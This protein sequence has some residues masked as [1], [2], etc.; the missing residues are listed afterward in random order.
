[1]GEGIRDDGIGLEKAFRLGLGVK[2]WEWVYGWM[3]G[4]GIRAFL[5]CH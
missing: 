4:W 5:G 3:D 1:M 2:N